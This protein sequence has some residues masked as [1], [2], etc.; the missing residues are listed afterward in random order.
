MLQKKVRT[1]EWRQTEKKNENKPAQEYIWKE[2]QTFCEKG[3]STGNPFYMVRNGFRNLD[4][5]LPES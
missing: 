2:I 5:A 4:E 1:W 3:N